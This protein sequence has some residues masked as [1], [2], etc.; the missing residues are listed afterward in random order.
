MANIRKHNSISQTLK[1]AASQA[2][3]CI[4]KVAIVHPLDPD[5]IRMLLTGSIGIQ[6]PVSGT[7][8]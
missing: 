6:L 8:V 7:G 2:E 5:M 3:F 1:G 4:P